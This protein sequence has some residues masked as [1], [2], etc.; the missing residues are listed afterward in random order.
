MTT[1]TI[2]EKA[3]PGDKNFG[4]TPEAFEQ[5]VEQLRQGNYD[6][7]EQ[8]F[9][10]QFNSCVDYVKFRCKTSHTEAY[11]ATMDAMLTLCRKMKEGK[12]GYGNLRYLFTRMACQHYIQSARRQN[13]FEELE[14]VE[15]PDEPSDLQQED[16]KMMWQAW[17]YLGKPCQ[18]VLRSFY[19][20]KATL[21]SI[22]EKEQRSEAALR[23]QKQRCLETLR[24]FFLQL[25]NA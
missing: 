4:L 25:F 19:F 3:K 12:V 22:A 24:G 6:F 11:D 17:E 1:S 20:D 10:T 18:R 15:K 9:L 7:Y 2:G 21:K 14:G 13:I 16:I 5:L 8:V 23:K